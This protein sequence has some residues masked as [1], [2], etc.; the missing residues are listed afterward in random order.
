MAGGGQ[1]EDENMTLVALRSMV[2]I[3]DKTRGGKISQDAIALVKVR[4]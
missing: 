3:N 1:V 4:F 2:Q